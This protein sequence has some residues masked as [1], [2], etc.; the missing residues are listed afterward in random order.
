MRSLLLRA[1]FAA[2][3]IGAAY[4]F[5]ETLTREAVAVFFSLPVSDH[6]LEVA[7]I[8]LFSFGVLAVVGLSWR[9]VS[10]TPWMSKL[11]YSKVSAFGD[12]YGEIS[13]RRDE[14]IAVLDDD[15]MTP[16]SIAY[17]ARIQELHVSLKELGIACPNSIPI[18]V[19][20]PENKDA[21]VEWCG[22]LAR[23][24]A[25]ARVRDIKASK[26]LATSATK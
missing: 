25:L 13:E 19:L 22:F 10:K 1:L 5:V 9:W 20:S 14:L 3:A 26:K 2:E 8:F 16:H 24:A 11:L 6:F 12:L 4:G 23:L 21:Y 7:Y 17:I 15:K 18:T